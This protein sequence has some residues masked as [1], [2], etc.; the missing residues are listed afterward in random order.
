MRTPYYAVLVA[1]LAALGCTGRGTPGQDTTMMGRMD[2]GAMGGMA[3]Q[4]MQM[5]P[6]MRAHVD[7]MMGMSPERMRAMMATHQDLMSR[8]MDAMGS[9]MR[10]M[11]MPATPE[12]TALADSVRNDLADLPNLVGQALSDR[13]TAH[14][15]RVRRLLAMHEKMMG[16]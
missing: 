7:S 8:M 9:D 5:M 13:M 2:T 16:K 14:A 1:G 12:W 4:G 3:M 6:G 11:N 15:D 10:G